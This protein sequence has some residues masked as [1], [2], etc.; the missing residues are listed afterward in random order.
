MVQPQVDQE[1]HL[2][3]LANKFG[4]LVQQVKDGVGTCTQVPIL[5][6]EAVQATLVVVKV[7][8]VNTVEL[9]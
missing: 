6:V 1:A 7:L 9:V 5:V 4:L 8:V 2:E 3:T